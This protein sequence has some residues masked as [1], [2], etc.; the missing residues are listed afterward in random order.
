MGR[1][2]NPEDGSVLLHIR[3]SKTD[4]EAKGTVLYIGWEATEALVMIMPE[5]MAVV[6]PSTPVFGL[7]ASQIGRRVKAACQAAGLGDGFSGHSGPG[8]HGSGPGRCGGGAARAHAGRPVANLP[9]AGAVHGAPGGWS[10][11]SGQVLPEEGG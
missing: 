5:G 4:Q 7:S 9:D 8:G 10:G 1:R 6:D 11:R 2:G 3:Q